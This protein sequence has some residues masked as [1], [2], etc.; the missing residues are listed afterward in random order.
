M[1][2]LVA[3]IILVIPERLCKPGRY[4]LTH[5]IRYRSSFMKIH[6]S[7]LRKI[8]QIWGFSWSTLRGVHNC[9]QT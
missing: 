3:Y 9:T 6:L 8:T 7:L 1:F 4:L 2:I 5:Y